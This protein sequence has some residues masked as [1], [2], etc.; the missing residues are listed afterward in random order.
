LAATFVETGIPTLPAFNFSNQFALGSTSQ[1]YQDHIN[2]NVE[3]HEAMIWTKGKPH[4]PRWVFLS[5]PA[6]PHPA[7]LSR[8]TG[9]QFHLHRRQHCGRRARPR[10]FRAGAEP[11][12]PRW[13]PARGLRL[14]QDDWRTTAK[15]TLNLGFRYELPFQ[16]FEPH[17]ESATFIPGIQSTVFPTAVGGLGFPGDKGV[18]PSLVPTDYNGIAPRVGFAYDVIG[19]GKLLVR[20][21]F[22]IFFD[23]VNANVVGVGEPYHFN[24][25][26]QLP[27]G[28][29]SVPLLQSLGGPVTVIP[30]AFDPKHP[31]FVAPYS[32]F[33]PD[34]NFRTP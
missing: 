13:H 10:Q 30:G 23:A 19:Q 4:D 16:W 28:G 27:V 11:A 9:F 15:L 24:F 25:L 21:G 6:I 12:D 5:S 7:G 3:L 33:F 14:L 26:T 32:I 34:R 2:E 20:G 29:A 8:A 1:A 18:L 31:Q 17:G 22:G